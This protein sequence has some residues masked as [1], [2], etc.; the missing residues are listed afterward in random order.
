M[1]QSG[2]IVMSDNGLLLPLLQT[3]RLLV[4]LKYGRQNMSKPFVMH[5]K[6]FYNTV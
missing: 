1:R 5:K 4:P 2:Q 6:N 3:S